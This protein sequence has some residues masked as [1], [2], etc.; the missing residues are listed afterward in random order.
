MLMKRKIIIFFAAIAI[1]FD[2]NGQSTNNQSTKGI[3]IIEPMQS[4]KELYK[5]KIISS[6]NNTWGYD[7]IKDNKLFIHQTS[8]PGLPVNE[9]FKSKSD[10]ERVA[11]L[12]I[13]KLKKGEMPPSVT[14]EELKEMKVI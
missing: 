2:L 14:Q 4:D 10:S 13:E 12:V 6:L 1:V 11:R 9:G 5:F 8:I 3:I 7:I